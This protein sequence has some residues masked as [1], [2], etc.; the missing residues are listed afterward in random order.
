MYASKP[1]IHLIHPK[2]CECGISIKTDNPKLIAEAIIQLKALNSEERLKMGKIG[3]DYVI[4]NLN[5]TKL[6]KKL[7]KNF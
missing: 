1:I 5:Y 2:N 4:Q 6:S 3:Y 7:A